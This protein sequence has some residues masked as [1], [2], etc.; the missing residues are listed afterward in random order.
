[1]YLSHKFIWGINIVGSCYILNRILRKINRGKFYTGFFTSEFWVT[2]FLI[3]WNFY[4][5][6]PWYFMI[7]NYG[8][9]TVGRGFT[10]QIG[11]KT[12]TIFR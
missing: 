10:H 7:A 12:Q 8:I 5:K 11:V 1:M 2:M 3:G 9:Y 6:V 4:F